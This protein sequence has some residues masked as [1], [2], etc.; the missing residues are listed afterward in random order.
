MLIAPLVTTRI[1][2]PA[3]VW[4]AIVT[5]KVPKQKVVLEESGHV[6]VLTIMMEILATLV[7]QLL[8]IMQTLFVKLVLV[9]PLVLTLHN[10]ELVLDLPELVLAVLVTWVTN[11]TPVLS[12]TMMFLV[13]VQA[14]VAILSV[15]MVWS[16]QTPL[17]YVNVMLV[18]LETS[19]TL[20]TPTTT[21]LIQPPLLA[22]LALVQALEQWAIVIHQM[23]LA[24]VTLLMV[25]K[26][27]LVLNAQVDGGWMERSAQLVDVILLDLLMKLVLLEYVNAKKDTKETNVM[28]A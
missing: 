5:L 25:T 23:V 8:L 13:F 21:Q 16:V 28:H 24:L 10:P 27:T 3:N 11:V 4:L 12:T 9:H 15:L 6:L 19:V 2:I 18:I 7:R 17:E 20:V 14:V 1:P 22:L 26:E